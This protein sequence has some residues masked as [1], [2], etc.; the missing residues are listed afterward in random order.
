MKIFLIG[1]LVGFIAFTVLSLHIHTTDYVTLYG[2]PEHFY[3]Y[4]SAIP[5]MN[6]YEN[7][8]F[9]GKNFI[10]DLACAAMIGLLAYGISKAPV[11]NKLK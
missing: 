1:T 3:K 10:I 4:E 11:K 2:F 6:E 9:I 5:S 8:T 7:H